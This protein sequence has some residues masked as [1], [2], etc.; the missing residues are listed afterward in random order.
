MIVE[1]FVHFFNEIAPVGDIINLQFIFFD[2][3]FLQPY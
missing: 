2:F 1:L 3:L